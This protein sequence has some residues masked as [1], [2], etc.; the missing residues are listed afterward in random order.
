MLDEG[1]N[2]YES[3]D[4]NYYYHYVRKPFL[5]KLNTLIVLGANK[6]QRNVKKF[7]EKDNLH[8]LKNHH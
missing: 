1:N 5:S 8:S 2:V 4:N 3:D 7:G 6:A